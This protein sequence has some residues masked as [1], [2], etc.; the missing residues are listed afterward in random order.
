MLEEIVPLEPVHFFGFQV[1]VPYTQAGKLTKK[2][3]LPDLSSLHNMHPFA[4]VSMGWNELGIYLH[5][6]IEGSFR[7][8]DFPGIRSGDSIELFFDTRDV[9][10]TAYN[11]RFC[12]HFY[13]LPISVQPN[14]EA[15]QAGEMTRFRT[16]DT[17]ELCDPDLLQIEKK[18]GGKFEIFLPRE[19]LYGYDPTQFSRIGFTYR[20][21]RVGGAVQYFSA[22][23]GDFSIEK[24]PS[25]YASMRLVK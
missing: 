9:K 6:T 5:F 10:T 23:E 15:I 14:G 2:H 22:N 8:P 20:I 17:H 1:D 11:T 12:H 7:H 13:F 25:L 18:K 21:N 4:D 3:R 16:E 24:Q 19:T